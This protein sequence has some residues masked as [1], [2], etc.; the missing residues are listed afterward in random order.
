MSNEPLTSIALSSDQL[1]FKDNVT[2]IEATA[3]EAT[4]VTRA[5]AWIPLVWLGLAWSGLVCCVAK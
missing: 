3:L 1:D 4:G 5:R 2:A